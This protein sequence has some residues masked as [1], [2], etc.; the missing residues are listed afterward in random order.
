MLDFTVDLDNSGYGKRSIRI[1]ACVFAVDFGNRIIP[2]FGL[3]RCLRQNCRPTNDRES[4]Y[5]R[6]CC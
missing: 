6:G 2:G 1:L 4:R 5:D 3:Y